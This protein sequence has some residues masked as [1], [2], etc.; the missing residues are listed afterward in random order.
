[1]EKAK[2]YFTF[3]CLLTVLI[4]SGCSEDNPLIPP[5]EDHS[6]MWPMFGYNARHS[7]N[8]YCIN[9]KIPPVTT[10]AINWIDTIN[11]TTSFHD[12]SENCIDALGNIY[13]LSNG[14]SKRSIIKFHPD[15][16]IIWRL[17]TIYSDALCGFALSADEKKVYYQ[18]Y[19]DFGCIDSS[20][21]FIWRI[22]NGMSASIPVVGK[23]GTIYTAIQKKL[24]AFTPDGK[25]LW[26]V[27]TNSIFCYPA[28]DKEGNLYFY[29]NNEENKYEIVKYN[30]SGNLIW[31]YSSFDLE[32]MNIYLSPVIDGYNNIYFIA[33]DSLISI[34]KTGKYHWGKVCGRI[35]TP[36]ITSN[37]M[38]ITDSMNTSIIAYDMSG[39][40]IWSRNIP[41][42]LIEHSILLDEQDNAYFLYEAN[43][44]NYYA[45]CIDKLGNIKWT[46]L[47]PSYWWGFPG[48]TLSP[49][50]YLFGTPK[51]PFLVFSL[52]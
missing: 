27:N 23:D 25:M 8:R 51:R 37:N 6:P 52:K 40:T 34:D 20:G 41:A 7:F 38:I 17:D 5:A 32:G 24:T 12:A 18:D 29:N 49:K 2:K 16:S 9:V 44:A 26:Q 46:T 35:S 28:I 4:I 21:K 33:H 14:S 13:H 3:F 19:I 42:W 15:G 50:G 1:M 30:S 36:A 39:K 47:L 31:K 22:P 43:S 48:P 11:S 45:C 10:G